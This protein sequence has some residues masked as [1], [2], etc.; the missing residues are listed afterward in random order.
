MKELSKI[1]K[2]K[3]LRVQQPIIE[4]RRILRYSLLESILVRLIEIHTSDKF[5]GVQ[6]QLLIMIALL[7]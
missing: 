4:S 6:I 5:F 3:E 7:V 1:N 2:K